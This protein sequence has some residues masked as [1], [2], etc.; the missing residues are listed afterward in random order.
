MSKICNIV[1]CKSMTLRL[2][3]LSLY[4][5]DEHYL[6]TLPWQASVWTWLDSVS[7][8]QV[9]CTGTEHT[10]SRPIMNTISSISSRYRYQ[11]SHCDDIVDIVTISTHILTISYRYQRYRQQ[12]RC[13]NRYMYITMSYRYR[14]D[15]D[16]IFY[17][18]WYLIIEMCVDIDI[19]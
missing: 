5:I 15:V 2:I 11:H 8:S 12:Y 10:C 1:D 6:K 13:S 3:S 19:K 14:I 18:Y 17:K 16:V 9:S 7:T 4:K